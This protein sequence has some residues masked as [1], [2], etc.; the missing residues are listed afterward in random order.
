MCKECNRPTAASFIRD[1]FTE[2]DSFV[3]YPRLW[4]KA[5]GFSEYTYVKHMATDP[6]SGRYLPM[7]GWE[8]ECNGKRTPDLRVNDIPDGAVVKV[9]KR[10]A[11]PLPESVTLDVSQDVME[12]F[13]DA[14]H[15]AQK[16]KLRTGN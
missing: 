7:E 5:A 15:E 11:P 8:F 6:H 4:A 16:A 10:P 2:N 12:R 13:L 9:I 3:V 1:L 14:W